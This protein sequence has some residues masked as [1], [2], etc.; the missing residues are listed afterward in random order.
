[1]MA[2]TMLAGTSLV[3]QKA[4]AFIGLAA[5]NAPLIVIGAVLTLL[6]TTT[7]V[8]CH[9]HHC[10]DTSIVSGPGGL[11]GLILLDGQAGASIPFAALSAT[12]ARSL[13]VSSAQALRAYN[14]ELAEINAVRESIL[15]DV[16]ARLAA[17]QVVR[18]SEI[19]AAWTSALAQGLISSDA[20]SVLEAVSAQ[21]AS[22]AK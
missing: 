2:V 5:G 16:N 15:G 18:G 7:L 13:G 12:D 22:L 11:L 9:H 4:D 20:F 10:H 6:N 14:D 3:P 8:S 21:A 1:M 19:H 17:G